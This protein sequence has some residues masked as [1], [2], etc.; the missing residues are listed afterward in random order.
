MRPFCLVRPERFKLPTLWFESTSF[1]SNHRSLQPAEYP[2]R[3]CYREGSDRLCS[4]L[5]IGYRVD[6]KFIGVT[7]GP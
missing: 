2:I 1:R 3:L 5:R 6:A 7:R 4:A